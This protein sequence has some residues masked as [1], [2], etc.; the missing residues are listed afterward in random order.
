MF[1]EVVA[2]TP[3]LPPNLRCVHCLRFRRSAGMDAAHWSYSS[4]GSRSQTWKSGGAL[5]LQ[6]KEYNRGLVYRRPNAESHG[7]VR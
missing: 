2:T 6:L 5:Y 3:N 7:D 1:A 4:C